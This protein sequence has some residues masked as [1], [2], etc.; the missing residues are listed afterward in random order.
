MTMHAAPTSSALVRQKAGFYADFVL[1]PG[2]IAGLLIEAWMAGS[3]REAHAFGAAFVAGIVAW[4]LTEYALHRFV[5]HATPPFRCWHELHHAAPRQLI[6]APV[7][8]SPLLL[9]ALFALTYRLGDLIL[10]CGATAGAALGYLVYV[11][12][13]YATHHLPG[14]QW[15][16]LRRLRRAHAFH[17]RS[18]MAC[19]FGVS[20][21]FW[22]VVFGT[23]SSAPSPLQTDVSERQS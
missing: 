9:V 7:W 14:L 20:T 18:P 15:P 22:D 2:V 17:H 8:L 16:W 13:H 12:I 11:S 3:Q 4:T 19:N 10:A 23:A 21:A 5:L 1:S 6:G